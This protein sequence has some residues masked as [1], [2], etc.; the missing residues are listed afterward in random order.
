MES[1]IKNL[2]MDLGADDCGIANVDRFEEAPAG[3]HPKDI[4]S[5]CQSAIVFV[6]RLP[7]GL[8][9]VN[10]RICYTHATSVSVSELDRIAF[11][12]AV[13][14]EKLGGMAIPL[15]SDDPYDSWD[16]ATL[17][18]R[19]I[20][21]MR[22]AAKFAGLGSLGRN[23]LLVHR[24]FGNMVNIGAVLTNLNLTSDPLCEEFCLPYCHHCIQGCP[25]QA[26]DGTTVDQSRCRPYTSVINDRGFSL[27]N[28][29]NCRLAC[30]RRFGVNG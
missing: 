14:I 9:Q 19:G 20:L 1:V 6:K 11:A 7:K 27:F 23:T 4:Y 18:G 25:Q 26:L 17:T 12:A 15:P 21:S 3:F 28:C 13:G 29:N 2:V 8:L 16:E 10:P 22:H 30:P 24:D 5:D